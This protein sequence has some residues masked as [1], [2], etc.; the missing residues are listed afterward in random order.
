MPSSFV[1]TVSILEKI[2]VMMISGS[3]DSPDPQTGQVVQLFLDQR[4]GI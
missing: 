2:V 1:Q 3:Q 4:L